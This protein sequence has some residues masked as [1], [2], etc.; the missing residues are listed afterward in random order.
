MIIGLRNP[1]SHLND[2]NN[3]HHSKSTRQEITEGFS[4]RF[5]PC[6][7][8]HLL[9]MTQKDQEGCTS[10]INVLLIRHAFPLVHINFV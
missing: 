4:L 5:Y 7:E 10:V 8:T 1:T 3:N 6:L 9:L 2:W